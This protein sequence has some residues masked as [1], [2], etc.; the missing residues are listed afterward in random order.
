MK[1]RLNQSIKLQRRDGK[2]CAIDTINN[3]CMQ[4][5]EKLKDLLDMLRTAGWIRYP[6]PGR[7]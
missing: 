6:R 4:R 2:W 5:A 3:R 1:E 7:S